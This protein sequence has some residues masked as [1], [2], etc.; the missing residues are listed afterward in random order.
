MEI[1]PVCAN[2]TKMSAL[3]NI[4]GGQHVHMDTD[5]LKIIWQGEVVSSSRGAR[6]GDIL[7]ITGHIVNV[8]LTS[9]SKER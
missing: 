5:Q 3:Q 4:D 9:L 2:R 1:K 6:S 7:P 8:G